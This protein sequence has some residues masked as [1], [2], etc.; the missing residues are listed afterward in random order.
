MFRFLATVTLCFTLALTACSSS[1]YNSDEV[2]DIT[3]ENLYAVAQASMSAGDFGQARRYLEAIDSRYPF[4]DLTTQ[5][6]LDLIY[7]Y[8]KQRE[9]ELALAQIARFIRLSPTHP[10]IDYVYYMK[11]LTEMQQRSDVIQDYLGLDRSEKDPT[12]YVSAF[13]TFRD[14]INAYPNSIYAADARQ[15]MLFIKE[16][17]AKRELAIA[18]YYFE[19]QAYVSS[20]RHCQNILYAYRNTSQFK[21][22]MELMAEGY[23]ALH[24]A[25]PADHTRQ[26]IANT[27]G[28]RYTP[29]YATNVSAPLGSE[30]VM[31]AAQEEKGFFD[32][33]SDFF[34]GD[35]TAEVSSPAA[36]AAASAS[37]DAPVVVVVPATTGTPAA[38]TAP[39]E[40]NG[41]FDSLTDWIFGEEQA[42]APAP[43][44][45]AYPAVPTSSPA[46]MNPD[47]PQSDPVYVPVPPRS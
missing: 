1:N 45:V 39:A 40:D 17:L 21:P 29:I 32:S 33:V 2:P 26:V 10:N 34:F 15:R 13:N 37:D 24:L 22:A 44:P 16:E 9:S 42:Q 47:A 5:V 28:E 3:A 46:V 19:R 31:P 20:I 25:L 43:A 18:N 8:Y 12:Y 35:D 41:W 4:G 7:V 6:Q 36:P 23:D 14:L 27:F 38:T 30:N 11:G